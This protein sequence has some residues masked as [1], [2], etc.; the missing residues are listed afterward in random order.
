VFVCQ[1]MAV[2][3]RTVRAAIAAGART[4]VEVADRCRAGSRCGGCW[5]ELE[6]LIAEFEDS[7]PV[8]DVSV[9]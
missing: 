9:A 2:T 5:P 6:R 4:S 3:D 7:R 8:V 1:C